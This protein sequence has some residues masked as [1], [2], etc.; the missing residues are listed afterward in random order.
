MRSD[1]LTD[2][3]AV[4]AFAPCA[5]VAKL[6]AAAEAAVPRPVTSEVLMARAVLTAAALAA[7]RMVRPTVEAS[8]MLPEETVPALTPTTT[9]PLASGAVPLTVLTTPEAMSAP[10]SA[11]RLLIAAGVAAAITSLPAAPAS[12]IE[13]IVEAPAGAGAGLGDGV[14]AGDGAGVVFP[15]AGLIELPCVTTT[16]VFSM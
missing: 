6:V 4:S 11:K 16:G 13:A 9:L 15:E 14:G 1:T 7:V 2:C 8:A 12:V 10:V 5:E 3:N